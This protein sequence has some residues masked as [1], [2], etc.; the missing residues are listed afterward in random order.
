[1]KDIQINDGLVAKIE[2]VYD[3]FDAD[4]T[5]AD[6]KFVSGAGDT[7]EEQY[8][9]FVMTDEFMEDSFGTSGKITDELRENTLNL[10]VHRVIKEKGGVPKNIESVLAI[11]VNMPLAYRPTI[12]MQNQS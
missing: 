7:E 12:N 1:M 8:I 9:K 11:K 5:S 2:T 10:L 6:I 4:K 3:N